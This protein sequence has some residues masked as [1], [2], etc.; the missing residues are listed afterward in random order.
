[1]TL[2]KFHKLSKH[3]YNLTNVHIYGIKTL[4]W[5]NSKLATKHDQKAGYILWTAEILVLELPAAKHY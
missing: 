2:W 3:E 4:E 5:L 1:M